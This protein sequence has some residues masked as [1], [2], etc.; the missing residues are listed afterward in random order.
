MCFTKNFQSQ[1]KEI[2]WY[3]ISSISNWII[4]VMSY[5]V[6]TL[7]KLIA[8]DMCVYRGGGG[9]GGEREGGGMGN[10]ISYFTKTYVV[11]TH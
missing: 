1:N 2:T 6:L 7:S 3:K 10:Y 8:P 11:G 9:G 4:K 5:T